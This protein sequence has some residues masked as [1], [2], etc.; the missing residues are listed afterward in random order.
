[1]SLP[2]PAATQLRRALREWYA[3]EGR[4][5]LPWRRT[6]D[7]YAVL[8]SEVMLQQTQVERVLPYYEAWLDRWPSA[9][10]LAAAPPAEVLRAWSGLGYN[11]RAL[12]LQRAAASLGATA[13]DVTALRRL[14]GVGPYTAAA[15]ACFA[16]ERRVALADTNIARVIARAVLGLATAAGKSAAVGD[17]AAGLLPQRAAREHN[18]ALMDLGAVVC[19][20]RTPDCGACP[21]ARM[22]AWRR[23]GF[24]TVLGKPRAARPRFEATAR[25][26]RGRI[27]DRLRAGWATGTELGTLVTP[28]HAG[29]LDAYLAALERDGLIESV[30]AGW[31]LPGDGQAQT[32]S[33]ASPK[34]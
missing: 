26:A 20:G 15:V 3:R 2:A 4:H 25:W 11:R 34:L 1:V 9:E 30:D 28:A 19:R 18:L 17:A 6:R 14:P 13:L 29:R 31:R 24:P 27:V 21:L 12:A 8:V 10:A 22:C 7:A 16:G 23:A 32:T 33:M 5:D